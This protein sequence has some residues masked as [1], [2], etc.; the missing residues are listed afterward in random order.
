MLITPYDL[1]VPAG[2][3]ATLDVEAER[4]WLT[5]VDP[6]L[7]DVEIEVE[8]VGR[9]TTNAGGIAS[10]PLG[11]LPPGTH[12]FKV[13]R[14]RKPPEALVR[15]IDPRTPVIVIDIDHTIAD[16]SPQGFIFR[17]VQN[18]RP[19]LGSREAL[20]E[21]A[22]SMQIVYLTARD[23]IFTRKT[24]LWLRAAEF[25]EAPVY[26]RKGTRFWSHN[27][28]EHKIERLKDLRPRFPNIAWGVG[29]KPGDVAAYQA[30]GIRPILLAPARPPEVAPDVPSYADWKAILAHIRKG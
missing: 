19:V 29:D 1:L 16:V 18:V 12:R 11:V 9:A 5:F 13:L 27:P 25:P 7:A 14:G 15:V 4:R 21:L 28:R 23:H 10:F 30:H 22:P 6:P 8:G 20:D 3:A 26:L 2:E 17:K 24:K